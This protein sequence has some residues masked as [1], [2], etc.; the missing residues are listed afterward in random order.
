MSL[1]TDYV[2][3]GK[4]RNLGVATALA[5]FVGMLESSTSMPDGKSRDLEDGGER[6]VT[7]FFKQRIECNCL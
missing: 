6:E 2:L 5:M 3:K 7:R 1:G 4:T